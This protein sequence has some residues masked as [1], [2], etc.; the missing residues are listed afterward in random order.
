MSRPSPPSLAALA[1]L[2]VLASACSRTVAAPPPAAPA[3]VSVR[4]LPVTRGA[5]E[6]PVRASGTV[7]PKDERLL[8]FKV[9]G[10]V[11]RVHVQAGDRVRGGQVLAELDATEL[12]AG[13]RQARAGLAKAERDLSRVRGLTDQDVAPR[14]AAEDAETAARVARAAAAAAE[15]NL[16]R[17]VITAADDG[18]VDQR[19]AEP[20]EVV[21]PGQP[22]L[23]VSGRAR[24]F[25]VRVHLPAS[26]V[27]G[28]RPGAPAEVRIDARP[29]APIAAAVSEVAR[30]A[31]PG[32]G[33]Y[34]VEV[35]L[36]PAATADLLGG[37]TAKVEIARAVQVP[38]AV[39]LVSLVDADGAR[40]A[41]FALQDGRARR[42]PVRIA[43]LRG[44]QALLAADLPGVTS[45]VTQ[46]AAELAD[47]ALVR[48]VE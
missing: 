8:A 10:L 29:G 11:A 39:P 7:H 13:A 36:D 1:A 2:L 35:R 20:G 42:V 15:F 32:T 26:D 17:A 48:V 22:I 6:I 12:A 27:L 5:V 47:G 4:A 46:G 21:G 23:Q 3:A 34:D 19:L 28:L 44:E 41:I 16:R 18:W 25:V 9:G 38:A 14:A 31:A 43:A 45:V 40:G 24:G 30:S 33:T 37:L